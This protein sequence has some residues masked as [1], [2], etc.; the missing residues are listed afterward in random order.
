MSFLISRMELGDLCRV[1]PLCPTVQHYIGGDKCRNYQIC[2]KVNLVSTNLI[3]IKSLINHILVKGTNIYLT[4]MP[5]FLTQLYMFSYSS[6]KVNGLWNYPNTWILP[7]QNKS[8]NA[9]EF[10]LHTL[11]DPPRLFSFP[12][13]ASISFKEKKTQVKFS[14]FGEGGLQD[15]DSMS[16]FSSKP[17]KGKAGK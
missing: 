10:K 12:S 6:L 16:W 5:S 3:S 8:L 4:A 2:N 14:K 17:L 9:K 15:F 13:S 7:S 1:R 11:H